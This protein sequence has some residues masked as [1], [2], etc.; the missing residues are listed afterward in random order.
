MI[1][2]DLQQ[3]NLICTV[4]TGNQNVIRYRRNV[5]LVLVLLTYLFFFS[6]EL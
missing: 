2:N 4:V 3:S 6:C 5:R 1:L